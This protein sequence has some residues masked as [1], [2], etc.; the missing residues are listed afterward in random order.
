MG[1]ESEIFIDSG[2]GLTGAIVVGCGAK[3]DEEGRIERLVRGGEL[4]PVHTIRAVIGRKGVS[5]ATHAQPRVGVRGGIGGPCADVIAP[6]DRSS[7][8]DSSI[9]GF[10]VICWN[11]AAIECAGAGR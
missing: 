4:I 11:A 1:N 9:T 3:A 5:L 6:I 2:G 8:W 10:E 7:S